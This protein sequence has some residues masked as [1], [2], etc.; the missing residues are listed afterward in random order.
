VV[1]R[2]QDASPSLGRQVHVTDG[3]VAEE[4][5]EHVIAYHGDPGHDGRKS[6]S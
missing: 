1:E 5:P 3:A 4:E 6:R 2:F